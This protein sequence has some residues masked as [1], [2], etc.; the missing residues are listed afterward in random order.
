MR[1]SSRW[2]SHPPRAHTPS[3]RSSTSTGSSQSRCA[4]SKATNL[5]IYPPND[6]TAQTVA[7]AFL[8]CSKQG[9][10]YLSVAP[11]RAGTG[12]QANGREQP[13]RPIATEARTL[14]G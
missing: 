11:V 13:D 1:A 14:V 8:A 2:I 3:S 7:F 6:F 5:R 10:T 9:P 4:R 12:F